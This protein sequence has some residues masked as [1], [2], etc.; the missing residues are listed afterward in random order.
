M[1]V[2]KI[3]E[4][5]EMRAR[6]FDQTIFWRNV[7]EYV[8][9]AIGVVVFALLASNASS[10]L[11]RVGYAIGS[12]GGMWIIF[13]LW[14]MQRSGGVELQES[15]GELYEKA[16]LVKYDRQILL[17]RTAW[18]WYVLPVTTGLVVQGLGYEHA[19]ELGLAMACFFIAVGVV[20]AVV[21]WKAANALAAEKRDLQRLLQGAGQI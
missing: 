14:L 17:T 1:E 13:F 3:M 9:A 4:L 21:N 12:A 10:H 11:E 6:K 20:I 2:R 16:L 5:V 8:A 19:P 18:A 7:R 15:S